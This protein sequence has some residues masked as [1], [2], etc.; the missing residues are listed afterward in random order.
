MKGKITIELTTNSARMVEMGHDAN[1][2]QRKLPD[3]QYRYRDSHDKEGPLS[4]T[5]TRVS[6]EAQ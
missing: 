4:D 2:L 3:L 1:W 6:T 5:I